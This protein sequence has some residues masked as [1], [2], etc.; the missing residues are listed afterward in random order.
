MWQCGNWQSNVEAAWWLKSGRRAPPET[1]GMDL[2]K[3]WIPEE[4]GHRRHEDD[5]PCK[6]GMA[7]GKSQEKWDQG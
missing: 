5:P 2:G 6:S 1:K 4:I 7:Q 3:L